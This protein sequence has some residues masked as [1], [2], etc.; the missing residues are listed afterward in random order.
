VAS[1]LEGFRDHVAAHLGGWCPS[2]MRRVS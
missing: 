2:R 1:T